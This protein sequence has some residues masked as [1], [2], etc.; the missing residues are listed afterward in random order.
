VSVYKRADQET[1]SY[2]FQIRGHRFHGN[3]EARNRK[4]AEAIELKLKAKAKADVEAERRTGNGPL[5]LRHAAGR[6]WN[7]VGQHHAGSAT[8]FRDLER[9][10]ERLG[11]DT[12]LD[13][14]TDADVSA[15]V[16]WRRAQTIKGK[17]GRATVAPATV[18]RSTLEPLKKLFT[19]AKRTW[20][21]SFPMEPNWTSHRLK[22]PQE[23]VREL[24][25]GEEAAIGE[26]MRGDYAPWVQ[27]ALLTGLRRAETLIRW[28]DVNWSAKIIMRPG[29]GDRTVSTPI[30]PAV[31]ALLEPLKGDHPKYVFTYTCQRT[32]DGHVKGQRYP[33]TYEG[34]KTEWARL[35]KRAG[36]KGL[37][38]HDLRHTTATRLL[39]ETGN[40]KLVQQAL[41]HRDI[42]TTTRY[43]HVLNDEVAEALQ[44]I[45]TAGQKSHG[46]SH[47][48]SNKTS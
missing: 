6:Y 16:A 45:A 28:P 2:D 14:I 44:R 43:A 24:H 46:I 39:R 22:E 29:K 27:F 30:T 3:T 34:G 41:N 23:R 17:K 38:F 13:Q 26:A 42:K 20:R 35:T 12:R 19:R 32:R 5:L 11:P 7:E 10:I 33:I 4:D 21:C 9:L 36:V 47:D 1:Y 37:R 48:S 8:T 15:L 40:L 31:A 25:D 18:N